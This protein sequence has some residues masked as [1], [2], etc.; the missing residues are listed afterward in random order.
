[1]TPT[2]P[3][4]TATISTSYLRLVADAFERSLNAGRSSSS[5]WNESLQREHQQVMELIKASELPDGQGHTSTASNKDDGA[6]KSVGVD[7]SKPSMKTVSEH[8]SRQPGGQALADIISTLEAEEEENPAPD[9]AFGFDLVTIRTVIDHVYG[10]K[11]CQ[12]PTCMRIRRHGAHHIFDALKLH[13]DAFISTKRTRR[14]LIQPLRSRTAS[15][16]KTPP[17]FLADVKLDGQYPVTHGAFGDIYKGHVQG[18]SV[19]L[20]VVRKTSSSESPLRRLSQ[21]VGI[22]SQLSHINVLPFYGISKL[23]DSRVAIVSPWM[24][25]GTIVE[26]LKMQPGVDRRLMVSDVAAGL[27]YL[28]S[29]HIIHGDLK[30]ENILVTENS[31]AC[32]A[33]FGLS[34]EANS[35]STSTSSQQNGP[36]RWMA[37]E[38]MD[39]GEVEASKTEASDVYAFAMASL[40]IFTG[41]RPFREIANDASVVL[42]VVRGGRP[43]RPS[44]E[45]CKE[46]NLTDNFWELLGACWAHDPL[47]RLSAAEACEELS[48]LMDGRPDAG[49]K[50]HL[51]ALLPSGGSND[52]GNNPSR[53]VDT[54]RALEAVVYQIL[55]RD[56]D[57]S[58]DGRARHESARIT[59]EDPTSSPSEMSSSDGG[60][61]LAG[62][63]MPSL[64]E[65]LLN[66]KMGVLPPPDASDEETLTGS[67]YASDMPI[68]KSPPDPGPDKWYLGITEKLT[69]VFQ[70]M[71]QYR[72]VLNCPRSPSQ[73]QALLDLFQTLLDNP[74]LDSKLRHNLVVALQRFCK[75]TNL[76]PKC[77]SLKNEDVVCEGDYPTAAGC[78]ALPGIQSRIC[79][80][81]M[82]PSMCAVILVLTLTPS[83]FYQE[84]ILWGQL[85]HPN[86]LPFYGL[87]HFRS[88]LCLVSPWAE[89]GDI[90]M[91][92]ENNPG[93]NRVLLALDIAIG[94]AYLHENEIIHGDLKGANVLVS[95][96]GRACVADFGISSVTDTQILKW[97]SNSAAESKGGSIRWQAPELYGGDEDQVVHNSKCSDIYAWACVC[98]EIFTGEVPFYEYRRD[99]TVMLNVGRGN[100][101]KRPAPSSSSWT[102]W[103]LTES[104]WSLMESC[105]AVDPAQRLQ[106][107][108]VVSRL[109]Q[110][111]PRDLRPALEWGDL[112]PSHFKKIAV[113][114][115]S[116]LPMDI[117]AMLWGTTTDEQMPEC[118]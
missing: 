41:H 15:K 77:F 32:L 40:E 45:I 4:G 30:G 107:P 98:Y 90:T 96:S 44:S 111:A 35:A 51:H 81:G 18:R 60:R 110:E 69:T 55:S 37:P 115:P 116:P 101:P 10:S 13:S 6:T 65:D 102:E 53:T 112:S 89:N 118:C 50:G 47:D 74:D 42:T 58:M 75:T 114:E 113:D 66:L 73:S 19:C 46:R 33:D 54:L 36:A 8:S 7:G 27:S 88:R 48:R 78:P 57:D 83:R 117:D 80:K 100:R 67:E 105:W 72:H 85:S 95:D 61:S 49:W 14:T 29:H 94:I 103:G 9:V 20:K 87:Y 104:I 3:Q 92:L 43:R 1:M 25:H 52:S 28:H 68:D 109:K 93:V 24:H 86:L 76:Y 11:S 79:I 70:D 62:S 71:D 26:F 63:R 5:R 12:H 38:L 2:E 22:W 39:I 97:T 56:E 106:A 108:Q 34:F 64:D 59:E 84:A 17:L 82:H 99:A 23:D 21:E 91:Y 31:R 16:K